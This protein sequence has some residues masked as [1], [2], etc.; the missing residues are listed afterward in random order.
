MVAWLSVL[1]TGRT[2]LPRNIII[3]MFLALIFVRLK[4]LTLWSVTNIRWMRF[5]NTRAPGTHFYLEEI[6]FIIFALWDIPTLKTEAACSSAKFGQGQRCQQ[7]WPAAFRPESRSGHGVLCFTCV[8]LLVWIR[9]RKA[10]TITEGHIVPRSHEVSL[11]PRGVPICNYL[12]KNNFI[13]N[14]SVIYMLIRI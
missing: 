8:L 6:K 4:N 7:C 14:S 11:Q 9:T 13:Q 12:N 5:Q 2:L 3:F 10:S 1:S